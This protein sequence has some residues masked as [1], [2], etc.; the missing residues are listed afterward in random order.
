M[1]KF[2]GILTL[3][4]GSVAHSQQ[5]VHYWDFNDNATIQEMLTPSF[6]R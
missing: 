1:K 5:L 2:T 4:M 3:V 6:R